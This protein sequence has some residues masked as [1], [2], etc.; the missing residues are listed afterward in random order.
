MNEKFIELMNNK[1]ITMHHCSSMSGVPYT[2]IN[3]LMHEKMDINNI[4]ACALKR[5]SY[6]LETD[7]DSLLNPIYFWE[8]IS[9]HYGKRSYEWIKD[10]NNNLAVK[11]HLSKDKDVVLSSGYSY[12]TEQGWNFH[13]EIAEILIEKYFDDIKFDKLTV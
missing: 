1:G 13:K 11:L 6:V 5:I 2:T 12:I 8:G 4:S 10:G 3:K 9:Y 7:M